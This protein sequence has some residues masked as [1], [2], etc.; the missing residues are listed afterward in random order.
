MPL[1][2]R[3]YGSD[4]DELSIIGCGGIVVMDETDATAKRVVSEAVDTGVNYFDVAPSYGNAE[5]RLGPAI[6]PYRSRIFLACKTG[7]RDNEG[8]EAEL[9]QSLKR[10]RTDHFDLYQLHGMTSE[11]DYQRVTAPGGALETLASA[12]ERGLIRFAG[13]SAHSAEIALKL[14]D[15]FEFQSILIPVNWVSCIMG[16]GA[17]GV[18]E[19]ARSKG[20][21]VMALKAMAYTHWTEG[22]ERRNP[23]CWYKPISDD[24]ALATL[25]L[26]YTL[27]QPVTAAIPP[28]DIGLFRL[29]L[30]IGLEYAPLSSE[31][32]EVLKTR[33][34]G[35]V[36]IFDTI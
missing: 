24:P 33:A 14:M 31:E 19:K 29:A 11:D 17:L 3:P 9:R 26:R 32:L 25:A 16:N 15:A 22:E 18:I 21:S 34:A 35:A 5:E 27:S 36:P 13:F 8:A 1:F 4:G 12:K 20:M 6:E 10:L 2:R 23:K 7:R 28:G 30:K